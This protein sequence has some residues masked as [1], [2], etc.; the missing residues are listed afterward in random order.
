MCKGAL[1]YVLQQQDSAHRSCK[2]SGPRCI[3]EAAEFL[4]V[5]CGQRRLAALILDDNGRRIKLPVWRPHAAPPAN[6]KNTEGTAAAAYA[7]LRNSCLRAEA[8][9]F[10]PASSFPASEETDYDANGVLNHHLMTPICDAQ[11]PGPPGLSRDCQSPFFD[12]SSLS[13]I[14]QHSQGPPNTLRV[15]MG[16]QPPNAAWA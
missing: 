16:K 5:A 1:P 7:A 11:F 3:L 14:W 8:P 12:L 2:H 13:C 10:V 15:G 9:E 4:C 6:T